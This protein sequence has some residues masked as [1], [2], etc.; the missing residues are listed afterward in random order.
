MSPGGLTGNELGRKILTS[1]ECGSKSTGLFVCVRRRTEEGGL[2]VGCV[3][4]SARQE[5]NSVLSVGSVGGLL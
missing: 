2:D 3:R 1:S 4:R 5:Q